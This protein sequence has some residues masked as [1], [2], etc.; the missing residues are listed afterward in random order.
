MPIL[1]KNVP[2][3]GVPPGYIVWQS[4]EWNALWQVFSDLQS[5]GIVTVVAAGNVNPDDPSTGQRI[6]KVPALWRWNGVW[7]PGGT[8]IYFVA[9]KTQADCQRRFEEYVGCWKH[10]Y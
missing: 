10:G 5:M 7:T 3:T 4:N 1:Q 6:A 8:G 2:S 9:P